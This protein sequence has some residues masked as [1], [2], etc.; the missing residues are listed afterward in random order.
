[1]TVKGWSK[2]KNAFIF[3]RLNEPSKV[4][5]QEAEEITQQPYDHIKIEEWCS[6]FVC[7]FDKL[8]QQ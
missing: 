8:D 5:Q 4:P 2:S 7:D 6:R 3:G 1:M